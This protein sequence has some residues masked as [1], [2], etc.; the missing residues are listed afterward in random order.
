MTTEEDAPTHPASLPARAADRLAPRA[1]GRDFRWLWS[2]SVTSNIGD[3]LLLSAGPLLVTTVTREPFAVAL[4]V[5]MQWLPGVIVGL[6]A[7]ALVD[8]LDRRRLS[9]AVNLIRAG[10]LGLLTLTIATGAMSLPIL[11]VA[12]FALASAETFADNAGSA[13]I[14]TS[15]PKEHLGVANSRLTG[16]RIVAN[17]LVGPP[18]GAFLFGAGLAVPFG[19]NAICMLVAAVL[20]SRIAAR[21]VAGAAAGEERHL[22]REI[23]EGIRWLWD[24]PPV[25]ALFLTILFFNV[26]FGAAFSLYVLLAKERLGLDDVG[27]GFL[28]TAGAVGGL[29]GSAAYPWL[30]RRFSLAA[31]M[32]AGLLLETT[33]HLVLAT[34]TIPIVAGGMMLIFGI[35][36]VVWGTTST[37]VRQRTVPAA[38]LGRVSSVYM[39]G[40]LGGLVIGSLIGGALAQ[41]FGITAPFWFAFVGS[42]ILVAAMWRTLDDIAHAPAAED[43]PEPARP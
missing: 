36:E 6:P 26:T 23:I 17:D 32:R 29:L 1:L 42:A 21:P 25:R 27:F 3:G 43:P 7:G 13:L 33:T 30:E 19:V 39:L 35:H 22:R 31:L 4:A 28:I 40:L 41:R 5:F 24:H 15:V 10:V 9:V 34:T 20:I 18:L 37:T 14:A 38:L 12:L 8:R 11:Y 2:A 16:T